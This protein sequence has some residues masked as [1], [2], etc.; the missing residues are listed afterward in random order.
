M[1]LK[2][3]T[4][5]ICSAKA[6][7][8]PSFLGHSWEI[9]LGQKIPMRN[10]FLHGNIPL[11]TKY[12]GRHT[13]TMIPGDGLGPELM[14]HVKAVFRHA[15]VPVDFE[16]VWVTATA[17]E[18]D[19]HNGIMAVRRNRVALK[20]NIET[21]HTLPPSHKSLNNVFR[22]TLDLY[23]NVVHFKNLPGVETRHKDIDI[24]V[25]RENTEG[26]YSNLE[27]ESV[28]GV[29]ESLKIITKAKSMRIAKYAFELAQK[30]GRKKVTA[31]HKANIM[32]LGDG[33]F[34]QC[35]KEVASCYPKLTLEGMIVD[36]TTM[37]LVSR[38][39]QFDVM[40]MPNLYGSVI[41]NVCT[42]LVG[43][44]GLVP[45]ANYGHMYAVF[46]TAS[47]QSGKSLCNKNIANPTAILLASCIMLDYLKLHSYATLIR[48][49]VLA[50]MDNKNT[51]TPDVGGQGTT[52][53]IIQN[54]MNHIQKVN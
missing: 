35:C 14:L 31:V 32:K 8:Q 38:P 34:L 41:N 13:V 27:H 6:I 11:S 4:A 20:G 44:A 23:A 36:N 2:M 40:V 52:L 9:F 10:F 53:D 29:I 19:V 12:G 37:Q 43:G 50:S 46:E 17:C 15:C 5:A 18:E 1:T 24:L 21:D 33:L 16:E 39:Q 45:G 54:I 51:H 28:K 25:V 26:E 22:T 3:L 48:T 49:A 47:R 7:F 30:M 42:G